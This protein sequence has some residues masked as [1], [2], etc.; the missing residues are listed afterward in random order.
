LFICGNFNILLDRDEI[1]N[2]G[3]KIIAQIKSKLDIL[4]IPQIKKG[5]Y[6]TLSWI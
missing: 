1:I 6:K 5:K 4:F 2:R 3:T